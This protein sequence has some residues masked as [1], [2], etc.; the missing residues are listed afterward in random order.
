MCSKITLYQ[1]FLLGHFFDKIF[2]LL[3]KFWLSRYFLIERPE[4]RPSKCV[5]CVL[6]LEGR[7]WLNTLC[8]THTIDI[9]SKLADTAHQY[10][11]VATKQSTFLWIS[12]FVN[13]LFCWPW[14]GTTQNPQWPEQQRWWVPLYEDLSLL[15]LHYYRDNIKWP[16]L[17]CYDYIVLKANI[18]QGVSF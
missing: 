9:F 16:Q 6:R 13:A 11:K 18:I 15:L 17:C 5:L 7:D 10:S 3:E 2:S 1:N 4:K 8:E 12:S 14:L